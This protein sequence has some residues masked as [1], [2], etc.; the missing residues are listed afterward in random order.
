MLSDKVHSE[1][2]KLAAYLIDEGSPSEQVEALRVIATRFNKDENTEKEVFAFA[3][4]LKVREK[5]HSGCCVTKIESCRSGHVAKM[6]SFTGTHGK[7]WW[8]IRCKCGMSVCGADF[9]QTVTD[10]NNVARVENA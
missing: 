7:A 4:M 5:L 10:W 8:I 1:L 6:E 9:Q 2:Y 3:N